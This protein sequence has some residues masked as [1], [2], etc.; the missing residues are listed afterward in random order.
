M[1][2]YPID[3]S[4]SGAVLLGSDVSCDG[5]RRGFKARVQTHVHLDHMDEFETSKGYQNIYLTEPTRLLLCAEFN[6]DLPYR[7]NIISVPLRQPQSINGSTIE[8]VSNQHMLG[9]VQVK[10]TLADERTLGYSSDFRWPLDDPIQ[11]QALV[12][13]STY[14]SPESRR[15]YSQAEA[16]C[17]LLDL[18]CRKLRSG[19]VHIKAFRGTVQR[20]LQILCGNVNV[21]I[22][23]SRRF[24]READVYQQCGYAVDPVI[25]TRSKEGAAVLRD[26]RYVRFY[27]TGD[28]L[29]IDYPPGTTITLSAYMS[30]PDDPVLEYSNTAYRVAMSNHADFDGTLAYVQATG[31][32][33]VVTDN[34]RGGHAVE[35]AVAI[36]DRLGIAGIPS[37]GEES[38]EWGA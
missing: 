13:D 11:V 5:F 25:L 26:G 29:P 3:V 28:E 12:V 30:K 37:S 24:C 2:N 35:L 27:S 7:D 1:N 14:G 36:R 21:A 17:R 34:C 32:E 33:F 4:P 9:S 10:V 22:L 15:S 31:A 19:P 23:G 8:L 16:E 6:A 20:A 38:R 18:V